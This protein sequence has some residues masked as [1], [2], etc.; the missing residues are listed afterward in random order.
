M[1][2]DTQAF[3]L[4]LKPD[5]EPKAEIAAGAE[6]A[7]AI[8]LPK[9]VF[10]RPAIRRL[11]VVGLTVLAAAALAFAVILA[12]RC[13]HPAFA[14]GGPAMILKD[15]SDTPFQEGLGK[16]SEDCVYDLNFD[17]SDD[18][19]WF[20]LNYPLDRGGCQPMVVGIQ[21]GGERIRMTWKSSTPLSW[22]T[23]ISKTAAAISSSVCGRP[24]MVKK[25]PPLSAFPTMA[26][27]TSGTQSQHMPKGRRPAFSMGALG[28]Y[29]PMV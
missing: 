23:S 21:V 24:L 19:L 22:P 2:W 4:P 6:K 3:D 7:E 15:F 9:I 18:L 20:D 16:M 25:R 1:K 17:G 29:P 12:V 8:G 5:E 28:E 10:Q 26:R 14:F 13:W 11:C 27:R